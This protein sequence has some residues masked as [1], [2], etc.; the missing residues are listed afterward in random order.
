MSVGRTLR[1]FGGTAIAI[2]ALAGAGHAKAG[3]QVLTGVTWYVELV[4]DAG[5]VDTGQATFAIAA[6]GRVS[7]TLGCNRMGGTATID[8]DK[9]AFGPMMST[10]KACA[11]MLMNQEQIYADQLAK[12]RSYVFEDGMLV[13]K[14]E[15]GTELARLA[16]GG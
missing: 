10:R 13:L 4:A 11:P 2:L 3:E 15:S 7:T 9:I 1:G 8:G 16:R 14:D 6:D 5:E 12:V